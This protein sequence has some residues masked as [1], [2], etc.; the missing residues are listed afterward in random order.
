M[1]H[2]CPIIG[3]E[4]LRTE[5]VFIY[6]DR[7]LLFSC[8]DAVGT[9]YLAVLVD[10]P[11][12]GPETWLY[13]AVSDERY[14]A[15]RTGRIDLRTSFGRPENERAYLVD[16]P[17]DGSQVKSRVVQ[18]SDVPDEWLPSPD[19]YLRCTPRKEPVSATWQQRATAR[20]RELLGLELEFAGLFSGEAPAQTIGSVLTSLQ[21]A[22]NEFGV[23]LAR[24]P[25][26]MLV[27]AF[28]PGSFY[29]VL[30]AEDQ[31]DLFLQSRAGQAF[32]ELIGLVSLDPEDPQLADRL[33]ALEAP[34]VEAYLS[35]LK[36]VTGRVSTIELTWISPNPQLG[37]SAHMRSETVNAM[38]AAIEREEISSTSVDQVVGKLKAI[39]LESKHFILISTDD[40]RYSGRMSD[41]AIA[42]PV[43]QTAQLNHD[44]LATIETR[45]RLEPVTGKSE[46]RRTLVSLDHVG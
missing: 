13:V 16:V 41:H 9:A 34:A 6:Y 36:S 33:Q 19:Q 29:V 20:L 14:D 46:E 18:A 4:T 10:E 1:M 24:G 32:Q 35:F 25:V 30:E 5:E 23:R 40:T 11:D 27:H 2:E 44:Y 26:P 17:Q 37:G 28:A 3:F 7:P 38:I 8:R 43:V 22:A 21:K 39:S 42:L 45:K 15:V 31:V 12:D